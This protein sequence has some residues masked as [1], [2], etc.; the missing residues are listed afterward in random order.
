MLL[1]VLTVFVIITGTG[2]SNALHQVVVP[3][4]SQTRCSQLSVFVIITGTGDSNVLRQVVVP[5]ISQTR[6]SQLSVYGTYITDNM[7]CAGYLQGGKDSCT[8]DSGGPLV[9]PNGNRWFLQ[10][11]VSFGAEC[12][13][14][15]KPGVY[16][17][18]TRYRAWIADKTGGEFDKL[19]EFHY[20]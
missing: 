7:M 3:V 16:S 9:C 10:G 14:V 17:R 20:K 18:I 8:G 15:N 19:N 5:V 1:I 13:Q 2:D 11:I 12:A 6:C 4:I